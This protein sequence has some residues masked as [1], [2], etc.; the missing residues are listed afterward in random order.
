[1]KF[2]RLS[3]LALV[4]VF[5]FAL[6]LPLCGQNFAVGFSGS[7]PIDTLQSM[8]DTLQIADPASRVDLLKR[9]G[10]DAD[11][12][13]AAASSVSPPAIAIQPIRTPS[14][15]PFG[16]VTLPCGLQGQ[17]FLYLLSKDDR[18]RWHV[19]DAASLGCFTARPTIS[20]LSFVP[21]EDDVFVQHANTAHGSNEL[22]DSAILY[23]V[24]NGRL[25]EILTTPDHTVRGGL[26]DVPVVDQTSSF[27]QLPGQLMEETR[28]SS[29]DGVPRRA[30]RR[31]W[32]WQAKQQVFRPA[33]FH[34]IGEA[35][36]Q[37]H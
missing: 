13:E 12:A 36:R 32:R 19:V 1:M 7:I 2:F 28:I 33:P 35:E 6:C 15:Q 23:T 24:Q 25:R 3:W 21:G 4:P 14:R 10:V 5:G 11:V 26:I 37:Q 20:L 29:D 9:L 27:L 34:E 22:E 31:V 18:S 16:I 17:S 30:E 8:N